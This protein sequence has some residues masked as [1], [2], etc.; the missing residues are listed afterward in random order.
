[1]PHEFIIELDEP[2]LEYAVDS[3]VKAFWPGY[4]VYT[5]TPET[6]ARKRELHDAAPSLAVRGTKLIFPDRTYTWDRELDIEDKASKRAFKIYVYRCLADYTGRTL[7]WGALTGVRPTKLAMQYLAAGED[8]ARRLI[9]D[10]CV[11]PAKAVLA[12]E[13]AGRE[14]GLLKKTRG[15]DGYSLYIGVPFCPTTCLYCSFTSYPIGRFESVSDE[16]VDCVIRE[17]RSIAALRSDAPDTIYVGGGTPTTLTAAQL[18][19]LLGTVEELFNLSQVLE[20]TVEAGRADSITPEKMATLYRRGVRRTCV[21][22]QTMNDETLRI[23]GRR[24]L[25]ADVIRAFHIARDA[26]LRINM[27]IILGLPGEG[28]SE[29]QHTVDEIARL[30][31]DALTVHSLA[32]KRA[33]HLPQWITEHGTESLIN[34]QE[35]MDVA[36]AA[37]QDMG[38]EPYY[39]Y[40]QKNMRGNLEN[41]GFATPGHEGLYN[42]LIM[43]ETQSIYAAGAG[44]ITKVVGADGGIVRRAN[45]KDVMSYMQ[46]CACI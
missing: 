39:L 2:R 40:R 6:G 10:Y 19:R 9:D 46:N 4:S 16:Y 33:A 12:A 41:V 38:M 28:V 14:S 1:M 44:A 8:A 30:G 34:T 37:A 24:A 26:G 25:C 42:I 32:V 3:L 31:P 7:P 18:D 15:G 11:S 22:P 36:T 43:E 45:N 21:N 35:M 17:L 13:I 20:Y 5:F 29:V 23:I 27:D